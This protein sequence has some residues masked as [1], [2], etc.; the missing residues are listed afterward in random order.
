MAEPLEGLSAQELMGRKDSI[1]QEIK[2]QLAI[3][4]QVFYRDLGY[5]DSAVCV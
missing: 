1:E 4:E 3:L 5:A 2:E